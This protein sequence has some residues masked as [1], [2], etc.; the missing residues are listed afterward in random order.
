MIK[1]T[2]KLPTFFIG[3]ILI[4]IPTPAIKC[5]GFWLFPSPQTAF[6]FIPQSPR[7]WKGNYAQSVLLTAEVLVAM[8]HSFVTI[9]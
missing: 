3:P 9:L 5:V 6:N 1:V 8:I 4:C 7:I 2:N